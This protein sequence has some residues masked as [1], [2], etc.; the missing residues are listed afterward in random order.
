MSATEGYW[1]QSR[2]AVRQKV[3]ETGMRLFIK[4][5]FDA[6]TTTQI[7]DEV[8]ISRERVRQ[9]VDEALTKL[10]AQIKDER[11]SRFFR[12]NLRNGEVL[13]TDQ[14]RTRAMRRARSRHRAI[15]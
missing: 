7:A 13:S 5:G 8:G 2:Q 14:D 12:E 4:Q 6:T 15:G 1:Q 9:I 10:N 11:P 3:V